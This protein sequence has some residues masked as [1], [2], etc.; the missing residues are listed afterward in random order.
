MIDILKEKT[1]EKDECSIHYWVSRKDKA[2]WLIFLHGAGTDHRMFKDQIPLVYDKFSI[3]LW[4]ARGHGLSR[5]MGKDF[6]IKLL[7]DDLTEIMKVEGIDSA[8]LI[9]QSM[10]GNTAQE[11]VFY[12]PDRV[13]SLVLI[14]CTCNTM[15]L[16]SVEKLLVKITPFLLDLCPWEL[17]AKSSA[18]VS[19]V[20]AEIQSYLIETFKVVGK[21]DFGKI[22]IKTTECLHYEKN[23]KMNMPFML[24]CG[25]LDNTGNI[26]KVALPWSKREPNCEF[27][28][29]KNASHCSHQD[30]PR[31]FNKLFNDFLIKQYPLV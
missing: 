11:M 19:S 16:S 6:S 25:E 23:Y 22:L 14:D 3:M 20:S 8:T 10:G 18:K 26:R 5:P 4:D 29:I 9:G 30:N 1:I 2:P 28:M 15:K 21:K 13:K 27:H 24:V 12:H 17:L 7:I 31:E